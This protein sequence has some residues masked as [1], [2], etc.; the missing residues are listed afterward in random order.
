MYIKLS[1][2]NGNTTENKG[3]IVLAYEINAF[4][5]H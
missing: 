5:N 3:L 1:N 4:K 2:S